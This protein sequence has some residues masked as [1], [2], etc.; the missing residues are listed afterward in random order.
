MEKIAR[1][2][3]LTIA[4]S[5]VLVLC[6][7]TVEADN[8]VS[9]A[10][11]L[12]LGTSYHY[13]CDDD[14]C[15]YGVDE[16]DYMKFYV[17][18][19][20]RYKVVFEND[21]P[22][23]YAAAS[24]STYVSSWSGW[25]RLDCYESY[26]WGY[27][28]AGSTGY[29][30]VTIAGH[31]D[32][33]G[34]QNKIEVT[35]SIDS[36]NRD[37]DSDGLID[38]EDDCKYDY[39]DS[40]QELDGC[41]DYDGD[42]W[43]DINDACMYDY[44]EHLDTDGDTYCD[45]DDWNPNDET[46][47]ED[48]DGDGY[49]DN[50]W[51]NAGDCFSWDRTQWFDNDEDGFGDNPDGNE[52]DHCR[53]VEGYSDQDRNGCPDSDSDGWSD[54]DSGHAAHPVGDADAFP[55][56][57]DEWR[58]TDND[59]YGDNTDMCPADPGTS[60]ARIITRT[61]SLYGIHA[62]EIGQWDAEILDLY[63]NWEVNEDDVYFDLEGNEGFT[64]GAG[65]NQ[66]LQIWL[67]CTDSDGDG[68]E[69]GTDAFPDDNTQWSD[70]DGDGFGDNMPH[71]ALQSYDS[72]VCQNYFQNVLSTDSATAHLRSVYRVYCSVWGAENFVFLE[73]QVNYNLRFTCDNGDT[74]PMSWVN[75]GDNDCGDMSDEGVTE[76]GYTFTPESRY[77]HYQDF[78]VGWAIP[79]AVNGDACPLQAGESFLDRYGCPDS[80][81]DGWS[82][83]SADWTIEDGADTYENDSTQHIDSDGDNYGDNP[84]GL[85]GDACPED[86][87]YSTIDRLGCPDMDTD[88]YSDERGDGLGGDDCPAAYGDSTRDRL[89]CPDSNGDGYSDMNG[90]VST[91]FAKA[92]D[93][94]DVASIFILIIPV[95]VLI[96]LSV[97][98]LNRRK[99]GGK[100][101]GLNQS[102]LDS[103]MQDAVAWGVE[104]GHYQSV[105]ST[106]T[107]APPTPPLK[108]TTPVPAAPPPKSAGDFNAGPAL[109]A[110]GLPE[111]WTMDQWVTYG[112]NW[113][114]QNQ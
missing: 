71:P 30:Y 17:Y 78:D 113:L 22:I 58:D 68:F 61:T 88:G 75:D 28:T 59:D 66:Y 29:R 19:G 12:P 108:R 26:T 3:I 98:L 102:S 35:L 38:T 34:D 10:S 86:N 70:S 49:G 83:A 96:G 16:Q 57:Y 55:Y 15:T 106:T 14:E 37:R 100:G 6:A 51:G 82:D 54:P 67:G 105:A 103:A 53:F 45:G 73:I 62:L 63:T 114:E 76:D 36:T 101:D 42:G 43:A 48:D 41:P 104:E 69:D 77:H 2:T 94:G 111:G 56:E 87:G 9:T 27:S 81:G 95:I 79:G 39:G 85:N 64:L 84:F 97:F 90:F 20:D 72:N 5:L 44:S 107:P 40:Y 1:F 109:P 52:P 99:G 23:N 60:G 13:V 33:M 24:V 80:D 4:I 91:T 50:C 92:V 110:G 32:S 11:T 18:K 25:T 47:W 31:D 93:D 21:C 46:Q 112:D 65:S 7:P 74:V 8:T 89:G